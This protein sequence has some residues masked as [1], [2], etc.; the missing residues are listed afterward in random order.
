MTDARF[1]IDM[2]TEKDIAWAALNLS[3]ILLAPA[4]YKFARVFFR[5]IFNRFISDEDV[6]VIYAQNGVMTSKIKISKYSDGRIVKTLL[7]LDSET[8]KDE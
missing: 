8:H 2:W 3:L 1:D 4:T 6:I 7:S 5:Y